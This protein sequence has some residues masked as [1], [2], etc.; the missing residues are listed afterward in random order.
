[1]SVPAGSTVCFRYLA[2][3]GVWFDD[4]TAGPVGEHGATIT[5]PG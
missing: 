4:E 2:D 3:G 1:V 5:V